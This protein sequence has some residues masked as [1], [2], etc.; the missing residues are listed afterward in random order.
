MWIIFCSSSDYSAV[1]AFEGLHRRG[2]AP[3]ELV[4][5][6]CLGVARFWEHRVGAGGAHFKIGLHDGRTLC[7]SRIR[8]ALNRIAAPS[9]ALIQHAVDSDREYATA[10]MQAFYLSWLNAV[11]GVVVNRPT[12]Q[13]MPGAWRHTSEWALNA[14]RAG[15]QVP[16]YRQTDLD[17]VERG[18]ASLAPAGVPVTNLVVLDGVGVFGPT[19]P[20]KITASCQTLA[21]AENTRIL[22]VDIYQDAAGEW[23]FAGA[24][25]TPWLPAGGDALLDGLLTLLTTSK[26]TGDSQ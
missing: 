20:E 8:G 2:L 26:K 24:T 16:R 22:G 4:T 13:G 6:E 9:T 7:S 23:L 21:K 11:P 3:L 19:V 10:E 14:D 17:P 25:P 5:T 12:P 1:W 18:Y 15:F